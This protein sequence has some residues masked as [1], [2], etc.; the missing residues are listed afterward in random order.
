MKVSS[1][2]GLVTCVAALGFLA[3]CQSNKSSGSMG[4][5]SGQSCSE[6]SSCGS[7]CT[8][9]KEG[10]MGA[11]STEKKDGCCATKAKEGSMGAVSE[12]KAGSCSA[13]TTCTTKTTCESTKQN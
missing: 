1:K 9:K 2:L 13:A 11:V 7:T 4:A 6:K 5:V 10:S 8:D 3:A 12:K